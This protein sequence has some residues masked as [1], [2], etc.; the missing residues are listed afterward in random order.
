M[1]F[2]KINVIMNVTKVTSMGRGRGGQGHARV[3]IHITITSS[4]FH[5]GF[6]PP[7]RK[8]LSLYIYVNIDQHF[9]SNM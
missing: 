6:S 2:L 3:D 4:G 5:L 7:N 1:I 8:S 9:L